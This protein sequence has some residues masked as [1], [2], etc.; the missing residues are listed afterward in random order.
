[1]SR[2]TTGERQRHRPAAVKYHGQPRFQ[3]TRPDKDSGFFHLCRYT[4]KNF[5]INHSTKKPYGTDPSHTNTPVVGCPSA[6]PPKLPVFTPAAPSDCRHAAWTRVTKPR[7]RHEGTNQ[8]LARHSPT[9]HEPTALSDPIAITPRTR[10]LPGYPIKTPT[11]ATGLSIRPG[12]YSPRT[13][14]DQRNPLRSPEPGHMAAA[15]VT[16]NGGAVAAN[17]PAPGR[18]A[19][20]YS[21]VQTSRLLHTLPLPSVLRSNFSVV[22]GPASSAA[23]NPGE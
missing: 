9:P 21:E 18:L 14:L 1:M 19:S 12:Q 11:T 2:K 20:V 13:K 23:G 17:G 4:Q 5:V 8:G 15:A 7:T 6:K 16:S 10:T 3:E 22:D